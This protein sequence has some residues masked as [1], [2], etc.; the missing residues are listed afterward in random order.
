MRYSSIVIEDIANGDGVG[1]SLYTQGCPHHCPGCFNPETWDFDGGREL[2]EPIIETILYYLGKPYIN[3]FSILGGEPL[4]SKNLFPLSCLINKVRDCMPHLKIWLWSGYT[5]EELLERAKT[6]H[7]LRF[8]LEHI[9][10]L[11]DGRFIQEQQDLTLK[12]RGSANQRII[13]CAESMK[14]NQLIV[15]S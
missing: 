12:W 9:D 14:Q 3:H 13:S 8:I 6:E 15:I 11:V 4:I 5:I 2:D 7:Y 1:V 10:F